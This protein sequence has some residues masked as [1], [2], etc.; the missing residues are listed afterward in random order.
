M[1]AAELGAR[2]RKGKTSTLVVYVNAIER[3]ELTTLAS[4]SSDG[5]RS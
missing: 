1:Q 5:S 2:M 4:R 3:K